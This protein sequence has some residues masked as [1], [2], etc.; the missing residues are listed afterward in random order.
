MK[1]VICG[2]GGSGKSTFTAL[3]AKAL[4][5]KGKSVLVVDAD[6]SNL[7]LHRLLGARLPE[8]VMA[9][10]GGRKGTKA[11][12]SQEFGKENKTDFFTDNMTLADIPGECIARADNIKL[13]VMGK[14]QQFGEGCACMIGNLSKNVLNR[15]ALEKNEVVLIDAEAGLEHFGRRINAGCD[16]ILCVIDPTYESTAMAKKVDKMAGEAGISAFFILNKTDE[17]SAKILTDRIGDTKIITALPS[18]QT[19]FMQSL[20]GEVLDA[21]LPGIHQVCEFIESYKKPV[22]L[23]IL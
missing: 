2:K 5:K 18:D 13:L 1:I 10:L 12:L 17:A 7:C 22:Q 3:L 19:L 20:N 4:D 6:E 15:L 23:S 21:D 14:I 11:A 9:H 8:I 16:L